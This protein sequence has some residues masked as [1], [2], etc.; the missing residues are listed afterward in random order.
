ML[1]AELEEKK[2][3][4]LGV[5]IEAFYARNPPYYAVYRTFERVALQYADD[6]E[7]S[8]AQRKA[9]TRINP[10]RGEINGLI[11]G[12][13]NPRGL[14]KTELRQKAQRYNRRVGD[15]LAVAFEDD[16]DGA[17]ALLT[18]VKQ[19]V[20]SERTAWA[21]LE[22][23]AVSLLIGAVII[24][25]VQIAL[26]FPNWAIFRYGDAD[27]LHAA[28]TGALGAFFSIALAI[29]DRTVLP[30]FQRLANWTDAALRMVIGII[31][32]T[33]LMALI[34][35][36][37][38]NIDLGAQAADPARLAADAAAATTPAAKAAATVAINT[39]AVMA[40]LKVFI[41]GFVGGFSER[42]VPDLLAKV[43]ARTD[44]VAPTAAPTAAP[45][46]TGTAKPDARA[47]APAAPEAVG[48][49][50]EEPAPDETEQDNRAGDAESPDDEGAPDE[51]APPATGG[52]AAGGG[53]G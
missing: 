50:E 40:G 32:A 24:G 13:R 28:V 36:G 14:F 42:L 20:I 26:A 44:V 27:M 33:V 6:P 34:K 25:A 29:K 8:A 16:I 23:V 9:F 43:A 30:D 52:I 12:W 51:R 35:A 46:R 49:A 19:D 48:D 21:R 4:A 17:V 1:V 41:I 38:V 39:A 47:A 37:V 2:D 11:D 7:T 31:A 15:A 3:D 45:A 22:Y 53:A 18:E 10:V 5:K